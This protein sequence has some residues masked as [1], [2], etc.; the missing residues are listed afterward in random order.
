MLESFQVLKDVFFIQADKA[1][2][3]DKVDNV[4]KTDKVDKADKVDK[5]YLTYQFKVGTYNF[6]KCRIYKAH[7]HK[8]III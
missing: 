4:D 8:C 2:K 5:I 1:D 7:T 3:A 6:Q